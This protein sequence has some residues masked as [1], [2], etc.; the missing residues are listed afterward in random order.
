MKTVLA[1][2]ALSLCLASA[3]HAAGPRQTAS[4]P[5][6]TASCIQHSFVR[7]STTDD[8]QAALLGCAQFLSTSRVVQHRRNQHI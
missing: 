3:G 5:I 1:A 2:T 7:V 4:P 6:Q 8:D